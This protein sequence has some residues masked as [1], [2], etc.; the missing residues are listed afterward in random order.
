MRERSLRRSSAARLLA[1]ETTVAGLPLA[2]GS[3]QR[4]SAYQ[5][6]VRSGSLAAAGMLTAAFAWGSITSQPAAMAGTAVA[7]PAPTVLSQAKPA[8]P[9]GAHRHTLA[10]V[11]TDDAFTVSDAAAPRR[12]TERPAERADAQVERVDA[13]PTTVET[14][15]EGVSTSAHLP[16]TAVSAAESPLIAILPLGAEASPTAV[17]RSLRPRYRPAGVAI[18]S[19]ASPTTVTCGFGSIIQR[20]STVFHRPPTCI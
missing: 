4:M 6:A 7:V 10:S 11:M 3:G 20:G 14:V 1:A 16:I 13:A 9:F 12:F 2:N 18:S 8:K 5:R 15:R 17:S 19:E